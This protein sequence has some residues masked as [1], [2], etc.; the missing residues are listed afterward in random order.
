MAGFTV[1]LPRV[2]SGRS[3]VVVFAYAGCKAGLMLAFRWKTLS[4]S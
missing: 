1:V 2:G 3:S 4:G